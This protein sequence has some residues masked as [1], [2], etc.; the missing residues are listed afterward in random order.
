[1]KKISWLIVFV[2]TF[3]VITNV[4]AEEYTYRVKVK[5]DN[6]NLREGTGSNTNRVATLDK[7]DYYVMVSDKLYPDTNGHKNCNGDWYN[8]TYYTGKNGYVCSDDVEVI[9]SLVTDEAEPTNECEQSLKDAGFPASYWGGLCN[10]KAAHPTWTFQAV[11]TNLDWA[12]VVE[13][14]SGCGKNFIQASIYDKTFIDTSCK[15]TS[16]GNYVAPS[17]TGVAYYMDPRNFFTEKYMFQFLDQSYDE[18]MKDKY[19]SAV[20]AI[21][22]PTNFYK[23][24]KDNHIAE[25]IAGITSASPIAMASKIR[26]ELGNVDS[27]INLWSGNYPGYEGYYNF[28]NWGVSDDCV[29]KSGTTLCGLNKAKELNWQGLETAIKDGAGS[30]AA[31]YILVGQYTNYLQKFNVIPNDVSKRFTHQYMTNLPGAMSESKISY[32]TYATNN[33]LDI[34]LIFRIPVYNKMNAT[35]VNSS[36]GAVESTDNGL[37][38][39]EIATLVTSSGFTYKPGYLIGAKEESTV[40]NL[41]SKLEAVGGSG[42]AT[43]QDQN[44][45]P[46]TNGTI[47]TG[48]KV[49]V[50]NQNAQETLTIVVK[51]DTSGDGKINALDLLQVQKNILGTY[52]LTEA[53]ALAGDTSGDGKINALD[54]LQVQKN[55][56]GTYN[57]NE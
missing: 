48:Y 10:L 2:M 18:A 9:K 23:M 13:K 27:L 53:Y 28:Y 20:V 50:A 55:I 19:L 54:L 3:F 30:I 49:V 31:A 26:N 47:A 44:G 7:F 17:Q 16:P 32:S 38:S 29:K 24:H 36:N 40:E 42:A 8:I 6:T 39:L 46:V 22:S 51:G 41:K 15:K 5:N 37:G 57:I 25:Y 34:N 4:A 14:E 1:M 21:I 11:N 56:L 12:Y 33:L 35:I 45:N 52:S 43:V